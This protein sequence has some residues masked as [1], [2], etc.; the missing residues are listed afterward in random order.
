MKIFWLS[1]KNVTLMKILAIQSGIK[2]YSL[3]V[4]IIIPRCKELVHKHPDDR[5]RKLKRLY[6]EIT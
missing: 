1:P 6:D 2:Q 3:V 5:W 4:F